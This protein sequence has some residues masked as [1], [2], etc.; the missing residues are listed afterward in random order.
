MPIMI[1]RII[2]TGSKLAF[3]RAVVPEATT[4]SLAQSLGLAGERNGSCDPALLTKPQ[5]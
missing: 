5:L 2:A 4:S 1:K 3:H